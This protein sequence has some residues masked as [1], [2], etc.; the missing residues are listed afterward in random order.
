ME[1]NAEKIADWRRKYPGTQIT[2]AILLTILRLDTL[3]W[4]DLRWTDLSGSNLSGVDLRWADL[5]RAN[6]SRADLRGADLTS[7]VL[8]EANLS[9]AVLTEAY[10]PGSVLTEADLSG[11]KLSW[12]DL[13]SANL[14]GVNLSGAKLRGTN[15]SGDTLPGYM[16]LKT[17]SGEGDIRA[18]PDGWR[19]SLGCWED[20]TLSDLQDLIADKVDWPEARG[21]ERERRRPFLVAV[22]ALME[23]QA[24]YYPN[25]IDQLAEKWKCPTYNSTN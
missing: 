13:R 14:S 20:K 16:P 4:A 5:S 18:T 19:V 3:S 22:A 11:A 7:V 9:G 24:A 6:L 25:L 23:A 2:E 17:P 1:T 15:L 12:A 8:T 10:L 21:N